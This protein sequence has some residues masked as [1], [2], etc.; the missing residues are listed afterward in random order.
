MCREGML[1]LKEG[2]GPHSAASTTKCP[3]PPVKEK[4]LG[5]EL[6]K[7]HGP[8]II[9]FSEIFVPI[10][11]CHPHPPALINMNSH[12]HSTGLTLLYAVILRAGQG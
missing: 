4:R 6:A 1:P 9:T 11:G 3:P 8:D 12:C 7:T 5:P 2:S 10:P